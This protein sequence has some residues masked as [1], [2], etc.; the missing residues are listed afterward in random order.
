MLDTKKIRIIGVPS[1]LSSSRRGVDMGP[2]ALRVANIGPRLRQLGYEVE[3]MGN[4]P[5][6]VRESVADPE[7]KP[8]N[9][10][11]YLKEIVDASKALKEK[12]YAAKKD[13]FIP[14]MLGGDHSLAIGSV[15]G[16]TK[17]YAEQKKKIGIIWMDA[18]GDINTPETSLSGNIHGMPLAHAL[19]SGHK[20]LLSV[21]EHTPMVDPSRTVLIGIRDLDPGERAAIR[22]LGVRAFTMRD[23][24]E[25]GMRN[26]VQEAIRIASN[27]TAGFHLSF[28]VDCMDPSEAPGVGTAV[29]GGTTYREGHLAMEI[30]HD[31]GK[32]LGMDVTE[33]NP[34]FDISNQTADLA[35]E[36]ALSAFGKRIL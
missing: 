20:E 28:D 19:G 17:F 10:I 21:C 14:L 35:V 26:V 7:S 23:V 22:E 27:G 34:V 2:S 5:V 11:R 6:A 4:I 3:D 24:D 16:I 9:K 30:L 36:M 1:D 25:M 31:S 18:H 32:M 12:V 8:G 33:V 29:R 13:G 15:A